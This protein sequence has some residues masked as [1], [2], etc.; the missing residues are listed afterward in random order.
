MPHDYYAILGVRD[1]ATADEIRAAFRDRAR[2]SSVDPTIPPD[3]VLEYGAGSDLRFSQGIDPST[4][5]R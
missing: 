1:T 3:L 5:G 4:N 2:H